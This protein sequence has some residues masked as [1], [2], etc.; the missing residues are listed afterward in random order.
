M[1]LTILLNIFGILDKLVYSMT[2]FLNTDGASP[3]IHCFFTLNKIENVSR[4][5]LYRR[6]KR[7]NEVKDLDFESVHHI[8]DKQTVSL[9][10]IC[11]Q[12]NIKA[13]NYD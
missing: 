1:I 10:N 6:K 3:Q 12:V 11:L 7:K 5:Y 9:F 13:E 4:S 2:C 8:M